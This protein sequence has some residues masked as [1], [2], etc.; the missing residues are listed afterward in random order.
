MRLQNSKNQT[1]FQEIMHSN[2]N[3]KKSGL[4]KSKN[5]KVE[6]NLQ[7]NTLLNSQTIKNQTPTTEKMLIL[8]QKDNNNKEP[9]FIDSPLKKEALLT[10]SFL[11][12]KEVLF[13]EEEQEEFC[14]FEIFLN[15]K[16]KEPVV[17]NPC[18]R[19]QGFYRALKELLH[20]VYRQDLKADEEVLRVD[21]AFKKYLEKTEGNE[22][23]L[24]KNIGDSFRGCLK[25]GLIVL[26]GHCVFFEKVMKIILFA[27]ER[28]VIKGEASIGMLTAENRRLFFIFILI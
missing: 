9:N 26:P 16:K 27:N 5:K 21:E 14:A 4:K 23:L 13:P 7:N 3:H 15:M 18:I 25:S 12:S 28:I 8:L 22:N 2:S 1:F 24:L 10:P 17:K 20:E 6:Y 11:S 19:C